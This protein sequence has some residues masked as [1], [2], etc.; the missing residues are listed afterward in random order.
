MPDTREGSFGLENERVSLRL[1]DARDRELYVATYTD[2]VMMVQV[3]AP[4]DDEAA[5]VAFDRTCRANLEAAL[6]HRC[7]VITAA[8]DGAVAGLLGLGRKADVVEIG[9]MILPEWQGRGISGHAFP[10]GMQVAFSDPT[11]A[12]MMIRYRSTNTFAA[13]LM[14]KIGFNKIADAHPDD[15]L[16]RWW[17]TREEWLRWRAMSSRLAPRVAGENE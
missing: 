12:H 7:W 3:G 4:L 10:L 15:G 11:V 9:G 6:R 2:P 5:R 1:L 8:P 16:E 13:G 17:L 14:Y